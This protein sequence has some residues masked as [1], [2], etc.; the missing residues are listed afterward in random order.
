MDQDSSPTDLV[1]RHRAGDPQAAQ[2]LFERYAQRL[3]HLAEQHLSRK[4][5]ARVGA[6]DVVQSVFRTFFQRLSRGEFQ[7]DARTQLW[8]LLVTITVRKARAHGRRHTAAARDVALEQPGDAEAWLSGVPDREPAPEEAA[9]LV[10]EIEALVRDLPELYGQVLQR[11][12]QGDTVAEIAD[13]FEVTRQVVYRALSVL[14]RRLA[15]RS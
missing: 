10:D 13:R 5:A 11:R 3:G 6:E 7:I 9:W 12:L 2:A 14:Q 15:G 1:R 8:Q 4:L